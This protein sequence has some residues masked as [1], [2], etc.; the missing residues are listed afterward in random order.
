M[1]RLDLEEPKPWLHEYPYYPASGVRA[2]ASS[3]QASQLR[4]LYFDYH[5]LGE[6]GI[7]ALCESPH[8]EQLSIL[9]VD[10]EYLEEPRLVKRFGDRLRRGSRY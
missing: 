7:V 3:P 2:V 6:G 9:G 4:E 8:L 5:T 10:D 1:L